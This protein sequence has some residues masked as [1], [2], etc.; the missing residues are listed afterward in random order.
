MI[1]ARLTIFLLLLPMAT[2]HSAQKIRV[3]SLTQEDGALRLSY[4][5]DNLLDEKSLA[6]LQRGVTSQ[7]VHHIQLWKQK[8]FVNPLVKEHFYTLRIFYDNW[9]KKYRIITQ[10]ENRLTPQLESVK[11]KCSAL[12]DFHVISMKDLEINQDYYL[13]ISVS[14]QPV[15]AES[16][17][18]ISEIFEDGGKKT[19]PVGKKGGG[20]LSVLVNLL[21]LGDKEYS[22]KTPEFRVLDSGQVQLS[23]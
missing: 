14:F 12:T 5:I 21:G 7:V 23:Q 9:E 19:A 13:S 8:G 3:D 22:L 2:L 17:N 16:Y 11:E 6:L 4:H 15:S 20:Y 1:N 18:A 10:D